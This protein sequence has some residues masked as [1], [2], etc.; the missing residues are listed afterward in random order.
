MDNNK[1]VRCLNK[2]DV[3][4][5]DM[6]KDDNTVISFPQKHEVEFLKEIDLEKK[7]LK[8]KYKYINLKNKLHKIV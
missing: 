7:Y 3:V 4:I 6:D 2:L 8:Y 5:I 1:T